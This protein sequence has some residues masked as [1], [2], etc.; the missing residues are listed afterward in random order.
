[1]GHDGTGDGGAPAIHY[2]YLGD[3]P[4]AVLAVASTLE[5]QAAAM[6]SLNDRLARTLPRLRSSWSEGGAGDRAAAAVGTVLEFTPR[7]APSFSV[8]RGALEEHAEHLRSARTSVDELNAAYRQLEPVQRRVASFGDWI[9]PQQQ[10][11]YDKAYTEFRVVA[12]RVGYDSV[13]DI[14]ATYQ[15]VRRA[16]DTYVGQCTDIIQAQTRQ[17]AL[18]GSR[19]GMSTLASQLPLPT[20][21]EIL[22]AHGLTGP[23]GTP[24][25]VKAFWDSLSATERKILLDAQPGVWG[26]TNGLPCLDRHYA[27]K[28]VLEK[29]LA[30]LER[31]FNAHGWPVP[32]T[33]SD[34]DKLTPDQLYALGWGGKPGTYVNMN[35]AGE[36]AMARY[37]D[38]VSTART[39][40]TGAAARADTYL[41]A[42]D[43]SLYH[44]EGRAAIAFGNPD[45]A[46]NV[47]VC[48]P[49]LESRVSKMDLVGYDALALYREANRAD[50]QRSTATIAWQGYDAPEFATVASQSQADAGGQI[51][52]RDLAALNVTHASGDS[53]LTVVAH[54]Y[55]STTAGLSLQRYGAADAVDQ[56]VFI[57]SPGVGG[58]AHTVADLH[59]RPDQFFS[60]SAS[61]DIVSTT[62]AAHG[63]DPS[64]ADFG[65]TR[66]RAENVNRQSGFIWQTA[67]HSLY[68]DD[69]TH[70]ESLYAMADIVSGHADLLDD[71]DMI[72]QG[73]VWGSVDGYPYQDDPEKY[74]TPTAGHEHR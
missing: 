40:E 7:A 53:R 59:L 49:G 8:V 38:A 6:T 65:G 47:A 64:S 72:A 39:L 15:R 14:D 12:Q 63:A 61:R 58:S 48:V 69:V 28:L 73:R 60:A 27:N 70:C 22:A 29:E 57:G 18:P 43:S 5:R 3:N 25:Q 74:R 19:P 36:I 37:K 55:G 50:P 56:V 24:E 51:L 2:P 26:N 32:Q 54:S 23:A 52:A 17:V 1:M 21:A 44:G 16:V 11:N 31:I 33:V 42:Y 13:A 9:P 30:D 66:F 41:Y 68:Y 62:F 35:E 67:D 34:F 46:D 20:A 45:L 4:G 71:H 10:I